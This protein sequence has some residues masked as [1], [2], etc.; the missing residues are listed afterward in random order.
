MYNIYALLLNLAIEN[1]IGACIQITGLLWSSVV[2]ILSELIY[3]AIRAI[4]IYLC[5]S[6]SKS[7]F[8]CLDIVFV[9]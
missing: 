8:I 5:S 3:H 9:L 1:I 6:P 2:L 4:I 7:S